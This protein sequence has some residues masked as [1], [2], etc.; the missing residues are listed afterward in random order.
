MKS[1]TDSHRLLPVSALIL[2]LI[3]SNRLWAAD[4]ADI[5]QAIEYVKK[6]DKQGSVKTNGLGLVSADGENSINLTGLVHFD[7]RAVQSGLPHLSDKDS[8][9]V[10]DTF[11]FRRARLGVNGTM[12]AH[13]DYELILNAT[14]TDTNVMDSGFL[15]FNANKQAHPH[16]FPLHVKV[17]E[18]TRLGAPLATRGHR[19]HVQT[20]P[21]EAHDLRHR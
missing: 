19:R 11:E 7:A 13:I 4:E 14:G 8:A 12:Y 3:F 5:A 2:G 18:P 9:S 15:N 17:A 16:V 10:A 1:F 21:P 6:Q 20:T